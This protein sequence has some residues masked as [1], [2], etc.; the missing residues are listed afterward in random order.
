MYYARGSY[1]STYVV[2][3]RYVFRVFG[4]VLLFRITSASDAF[5]VFRIAEHERHTDDDD[6]DGDTRIANANMYRMN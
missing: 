2:V 3:T 4:S 5:L 1:E 6:D